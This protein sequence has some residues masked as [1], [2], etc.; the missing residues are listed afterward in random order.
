VV[1]LTKYAFTELPV[2]GAAVD[3]SKVAAIEAADI[4][5]AGLQS[6]I[7]DYT[8]DGTFDKLVEVGLAAKFYTIFKRI[9]DTR[10][11]YNLL[12]FDSEGWTII[13][14]GAYPL[15][16]ARSF[17]QGTGINVGLLSY[18]ASG[19]NDSGVAYRIIAYG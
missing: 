13:F 8:G 17:V 9:D 18:Y 10:D 14:S 12:V 6:S 15:A 11:V 2:V 1:E 16:E 3:P 4:P 5:G 7:T 19:G